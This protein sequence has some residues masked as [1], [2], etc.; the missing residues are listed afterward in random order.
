MAR[1]R[2]ELAQLWV[3]LAQRQREIASRDVELAAR[4]ASIWR[5]EDQLT[6]LGIGPL[7]RASSSGHG[8]AS[9]PAPPDPVSL[10]WFFD[11]PPPS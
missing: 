10:D 5:L 2:A 8:Q 9:S 11:D 4:D 6:S 7:T 1:L 3:E